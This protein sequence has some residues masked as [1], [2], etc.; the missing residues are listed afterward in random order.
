MKIKGSLL[1]AH[2]VPAPLG[3]VGHGAGLAVRAHVRLLPL[4]LR[5]YG[6]V[7]LLRAADIGLF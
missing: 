6:A 5:Q 1:F 7:L 4:P 3:V 2:G